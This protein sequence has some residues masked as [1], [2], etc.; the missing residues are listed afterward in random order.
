MRKKLLFSLATC[1]TIFGGA[2]IGLRLANGWHRHWLDC[3]RWHP[4]LGWSLR[5]GWAGNWAWTGGFSRINAQGLRADQPVGPK[6]AGERRLLVVG[7]SVTFGAKVQ[8]GQAYP[9]QLEQALRAA[10]ADWHV[11][12][13]GVSG[14]DPAQERDWL[15]ELGWPLE[16]DVVAVAFCRNDV[17]PSQRRRPLAVG[18][19]HQAPQPPGVLGRWLTEHSIV[20]DRLQRGVWLAAAHL[21]WAKATADAADTDDQVAGWPF[22]EHAYRGMAQQARARGCPVV[23]FIYPTLDGLEG[24]TVDQLSEQLQALGAELGW[25]VIDLA[26]A[27]TPDAADLFF[28]GDAFHPNAAGYQRVAAYAAQTLTAKA[29]LPTA[30]GTILQASSAR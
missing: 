23:L 3:H 19:K 24:R 13:G 9:A 15:A 10:G 17:S 14:Y 21:G 27:F 8:T 25:A 12:N 16:P 20:A 6:T 5:E 4:L 26:P 7:D 22:V 28:A 2:E 11:L 1:L 29:I 18:N 30:A